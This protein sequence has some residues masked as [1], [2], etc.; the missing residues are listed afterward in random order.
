MSSAGHVLDAI[1]RMANNRRLLL[2]RRE[3]YSQI[4]SKY[5]VSLKHEG[6]HS[7][8][9]KIPKEKLDKIKNNIRSQI[10]KERRRAFAVSASITLVIAAVVALIVIRSI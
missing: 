6:F 5:E 10:L 8:H 9:D 7:R 2:Q 4:K 1:S 3:R